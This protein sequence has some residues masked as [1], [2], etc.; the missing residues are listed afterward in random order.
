MADKIKVFFLEPT[1]RER[2]WL[3]RFQFSSKRKC[4]GNEYGCDAMFEIGEADILYSSEGYIKARKAPSIT[5]PRWPKTC[6]NCGQPFQDG[7]E[8]QLHGKQIYLRADTGER[9]TLRDAPPGACWDAWWI[10]D[11]KK[12]CPTG[13][14]HMVGPDHRSLVVKCPDG[15]EWM[16][17][18][19]ASN[20]TLP[21]DNT[22][23]CWVR[24]GKPEDGTLHVDKNGNTCAAG[25]G[26]IATGK[27]HGFLHNGYL[28]SC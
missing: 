20:C 16:I 24:H 25:A 13:C 23:Q 11:R 7:D 5:D 1:D 21:G 6:K 3:R 4:A 26:S 2:Q 27:W 28:V 19:R 9:Y 10:T 12:D 15:H 18:N 14:G 22:H 8:Y 17:D